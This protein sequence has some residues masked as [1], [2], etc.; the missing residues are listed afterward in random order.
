MRFILIIA[1]F[2]CCLVLALAHSFRTSEE[3]KISELLKNIVMAEDSSD[4]DFI[5]DDDEFFSILAKK[6]FQYAQ[7]HKS[8]KRYA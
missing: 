3:N 8:K 1:L 7:G 2:A 5:I 4:H 6:E